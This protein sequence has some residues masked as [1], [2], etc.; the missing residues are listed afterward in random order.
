MATHKTVALALAPAII[1]LTAASCMHDMDGMHDG[2]DD[3]AIDY[4][5]GFVVNGA[6]ND[7]SVFR[8]SD[9]TVTETIAL[10]G[11][12][13]PHHVYLSPDG[14]KLAVAIT[15]TDLSGGHA[16]HGSA[17]PGQKIQ[18]IDAITGKVEREI[19]VPH[20]P[21]NAA[22]NPAGTELWVSQ[23]DEANP[24]VLVYRTSD[25]TLTHTISVGKAPS[26]LTF[27]HD[28][29]A[30]FSANTGD[31]TVSMIDPASKAVLRVIPVGEDPVGAWPAPNGKMY[32]DNERS[33][34]VSE[35]DVKSGDV[36]A[37]IDLNFMPAYAAYSITRDELWVTDATHG[38]VVRY[39]KTN[40]VW[41]RI[42]DITTGTN[43]HAIAFSAGGKLAYVTNQ[44]ANTLSV[45]DVQT[46]SVTKTLQVGEQPNGLAIR[47]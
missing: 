36:T 37:T 22:F 5:A 38:M 27:S 15:G 23:S 18:I 21:H 42:G 32:V 31:G 29:T 10:D 43:T 19:A 16:G 35:I 41:E 33:E 2:Q 47:H 26:E 9:L 4:P 7:L 17:T 14:K 30:A 40:G 24:K 1:L 28:G 13:F 8:L 11:A 39:A 20:L 3:L 34:T 6:S 46:L 45:V 12:Q 44:G 25:F